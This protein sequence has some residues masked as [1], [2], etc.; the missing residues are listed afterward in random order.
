MHIMPK[1]KLG[2]ISLWTTIAAFLLLSLKSWLSRFP[3]AAAWV[4]IPSFLQMAIM[5][6]GGIASIIS[7]IKYKDRAVLLFLSSLI[8]ILA[9]IFAFGELLFPL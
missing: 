1:T 4:P 2:K 3:G 9:L 5:I 7:V 6:S 8:G